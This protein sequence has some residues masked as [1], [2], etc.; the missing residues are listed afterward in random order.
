MKKTKLTREE[1][2]KACTQEL[3]QAVDQAKQIREKLRQLE[4]DIS[5]KQ[6]KIRN[7][8]QKFTDLQ[9]QLVK[10]QAIIYSKGT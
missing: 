8:E 4:E 6:A 5:G 1:F 10:I 7:Y 3:Q 2:E 9:T